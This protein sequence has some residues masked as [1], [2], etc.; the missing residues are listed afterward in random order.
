MVLIT[1]AVV[2]LFL[3]TMLGGTTLYKIGFVIDE[4]LKMKSDTEPGVE[5]L[6]CS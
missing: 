3:L 2:F 4:W 6:I 1:R 5:R